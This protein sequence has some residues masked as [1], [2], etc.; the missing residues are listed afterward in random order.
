MTA[1]VRRAHILHLATLDFTTARTNIV[2]FRVAVQF[3]AQQSRG[4]GQELSPGANS[5]ACLG[6]WL[7]PILGNLLSILARTRQYSTTARPTAQLAETG[8]PGT[9]GRRRRTSC[10]VQAGPLRRGQQNP[11]RS[12]LTRPA[13]S[14]GPSLSVTSGAN[15][16]PEAPSLSL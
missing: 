10:Y 13:Y 8:H 12:S 16:M 9:S 5:F 15:F 3:G 1:H 2:V 6:K 14:G 11:R 4:P 7:G